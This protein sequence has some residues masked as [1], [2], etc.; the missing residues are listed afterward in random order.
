MK[1]KCIRTLYLGAALTALLATPAAAQQEGDFSFSLD[2]TFVNRYLW[3]GFKVNDSPA[4]QPN[5][6]FGYKGLSV[7]SWS[8]FQQNRVDQGVD[9]GQN[10]I[11]HDL[12]VDYSHGFDNGLGVSVGYI[13]Y[14]F[15]GTPRSDPAA[16]SH[17]FYAGVSYDTVLS[18]SFT[19]YRDVDQGDGNYFYFSVGHSQDLGKGL[20]LNLGTG[21]G[22]NNKQWI[23]I[24]TVSNWDINVSVNIP[25]GKVVFSPFF[26]QMIGNESIF[27]KNNAWGCNISVL[28][29]TF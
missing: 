19:F 9:W 17:E 15:P 1:H 5:L 13:W 24:T 26:T 22:L 8:S 29:L 10:W 28:S 18:P 25:W 4:L 6:S 3:R 21:A 23:D 16:D 2:A 12:T 27:G 20:A 11:E 7:S 14:A